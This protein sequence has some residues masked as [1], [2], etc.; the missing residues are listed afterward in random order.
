MT[1][2]SKP[3]TSRQER[4]QVFGPDVMPG[5]WPQL[6]VPYEGWERDLSYFLACVYHQCDT[7][8]ADETYDRL[9]GLFQYEKDL[10][11]P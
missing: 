4:Y 7:K 2:C 11:E 8:R 10:V 3:S 9:I 5:A 1:E 6:F